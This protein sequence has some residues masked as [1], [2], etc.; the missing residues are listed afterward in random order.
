MASGY[1]LSYSEYSYNDSRPPETIVIVN[2]VL[3]APLMILSIIGNTLVLA[4]IL[5]TSSLRSP[6]TVLLCSLAASDL[7]VGL[8]LQPVYIAAYLTKSVYMQK[9]MATIAFAACGVSLFTITAITV[10][11]FL[12]LHYH[13]RYP[14]LMT[15]SRAVYIS[16]T[17]WIIAILLSFSRLW[18]KRVYAG[19]IAA[20]IAICLLI[21]TACY[22]RIYRIVRQHQLQIQIQRQAVA[23]FNTENNQHMKQ[24]A[25]SAKNTLIYYIVMILCYTPMFIVKLISG[26]YPNHLTIMWILTETLVFVNSSINPFLYCWRLRELRVAVIKAAKYILCKQT[27][28]N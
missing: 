9:S 1:E 2:C 18:E 28:E 27:E 19:S 10:D 20:C 23:S 22:I 7:L 14:N 15:T 26:I 13:L 17:L 6:N 21:C 25:R 12:V 3:N 24:S 16:A 11:R 8:V 4:A 5:R